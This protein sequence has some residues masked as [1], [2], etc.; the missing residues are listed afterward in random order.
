[1]AAAVIGLLVEAI[2]NSESRR[3][4]GR[5]TAKPPERFDLYIVAYRHQRDQP[6]DVRV[7]E[8]PLRGP[9]DR[10]ET[11]RLTADIPVSS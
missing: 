7:A 4:D 8:V 10:L 6:D 5:P 1:M 9:A 3:T 11:H 2:R